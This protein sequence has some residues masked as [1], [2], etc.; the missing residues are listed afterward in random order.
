MKKFLKITGLILL[1]LFVTLITAPFLFKDKIR[2]WVQ[3]DI[4]KLFNAEIY[5]SDVGLSFIKNFPDARISISDF[6]VVGKE[7]FAGDTLAAGKNFHL[8]VDIMSVISGEEIGLKKVILD[9]PQIHAIVLKDGTANWD[10]MAPDTTTIENDTIPADTG[11]INIK[12]NEYRLNNARIVYEDATLPMKAEIIGLN[13]SGSGNFTLDVYDLVT[14]T[15]AEKLTVLYDGVKYLNKIKLDADVEMKIDME[16][17]QGLEFRKTYPVSAY[18]T[19]FFIDGDGNIV[20]KVTGARPPA[21]FIQ[22]AQAAVEKYDPSAA[23]AKAYEGGDRSFERVYNYVKSLNKMHQPSLAISN[24]YLNAQQDLTTPDNL[25]FLFE[26]MIEADSRIF[27]L[28]IENRAGIEGQ[29]GADAV[30]QR[31][32]DACRATA[33]KA[34]EFNMDVLLTEAQTKVRKYVPAQADEFIEES[35]LAFAKASGDAKTY[36]ALSKDRVSGSYKKDASRLHAVASEMVTYFNQDPDAMNYA[37]KLAKKACS[38]GGQAEYFL[39]Y[40]QILLHQ[41]NPEDAKMQAK[42][43]LKLA[44]ERKEDCGDIERFLNSI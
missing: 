18:P 34:L 20:S 28:F 21:Q 26:A 39:T 31:I 33:D 37:A 6:G 15:S 35:S 2:A 22:V 23:F 7:P 9:Q 24:D 16:K 5:F 29:M 8:V 11:N 30:N 13:H 44:Q 14:K 4:D 1:I 32:V 3:N 25:R 43:A 42:H 17:G 41:G 10:I 27:D 12:L 38:Y 36:I 40:A 19:F